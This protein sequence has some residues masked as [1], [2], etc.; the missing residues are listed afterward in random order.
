[1]LLLFYKWLQAHHWAGNDWM[2]GAYIFRAA[3]AILC[4][5]LTV[6]LSGGRVIRWLMTKKLGDNPEFH[7]AK[8]NDL[9][10]DKKNTP[11][12]GGILIIATI[13]V[14]CLV[15]ADIMNFY[16]RMALFCMVYLA[17][18]GGVDDWLKLTQARRT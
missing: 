10:K 5:F 18:L 1:M 8:L 17:C 7:V 11:T 6:L 9:T 4:S 15:F 3:L 2:L 16:V 13:L 12:M 14:N